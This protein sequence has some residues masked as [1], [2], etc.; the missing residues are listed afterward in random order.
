MKI[1]VTGSEGQ[2]GKSLQKLAPEYNHMEFTWTDIHN[3]DITD[4]KRLEQIFSDRHFNYIINCAAYTAVDKAEEEPEIA[5]IL[6]VEAPGNLARMATRYGIVLIQISTDFIF[7]G[8]KKEPY[9]ETDIPKPNGIYA[10]SKYRGEQEV[11]KYSNKSIVIRTSWLY[12]EFGKN[13]VKTILHYAKEREFL[14]V[15]HDQIGSPTY[16]TDLAKALL[17]MLDTKYKPHTNEIFHYSNRGIISWFDFAIAIVSLAGIDCQ[18][19]PISTEEYNAP[20]PRPSYSAMSQEKIMK[21]FALT[22]PNWED[23][24]KKC[25]EILKNQTI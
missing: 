9:I 5:H 16:A 15:V 17:T 18:V 6:N 13:F 2:L 20:A 14:K 23:S 3:L 1:L 21:K 22:I 19:Y 4:H 12:S 7:D 24:L 10:A 11:M 8:S 25:L